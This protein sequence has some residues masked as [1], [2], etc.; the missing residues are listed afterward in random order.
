MKNNDSNLNHF[1]HGSVGAISLPFKLNDTSKIKIT[2]PINMPKLH[3]RKNIKPS[4]TRK[5]TFDNLFKVHSPLSI[6]SMERKHNFQE[7]NINI[8]NLNINNY[9]IYDT[10]DSKDDSRNKFPVINQKHFNSFNKERDV[11]TPKSNKREALQKFINNNKKIRK[12]KVID[13]KKIK[14]HQPKHISIDSMNK[15]NENQLDN[16]KEDTIP[17]KPKIELCDDNND[18]FMDELA[19]LLNVKVNTRNINKIEDTESEEIPIINHDLKRPDTSYGGLCDRKRNLQS[20]LK[21][22]K[23]RKIQK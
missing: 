23:N 6:S 19:D 15:I 18:S 11:F 4:L 1:R 10:N 5:F 3:T 9:N 7:I 17:S 14:L 21:S 13:I 2:F 22:A 8:Q 20:A 12:L 16:I